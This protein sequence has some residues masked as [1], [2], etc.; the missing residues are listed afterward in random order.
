MID[1][2]IEGETVSAKNEKSGVRH[3]FIP[4]LNW[5]LKE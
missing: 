1:K 4:D 2:N 3:R 5:C